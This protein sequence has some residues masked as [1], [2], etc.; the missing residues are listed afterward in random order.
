MQTRHTFE[1]SCRLIHGMRLPI[2]FT[3]QTEYGILLRRIDHR[4]PHK[5][6]SGRDGR[7]APATPPT[8]PAGCLPTSPRPR[9]SVLAPPN[10]PRPLPTSS[11]RLWTAVSHHSSLC[12]RSTPTSPPPHKPGI[13]RLRTRP[14]PQATTPPRPPPSQTSPHS[15]TPPPHK[16]PP[17]T[18][19]TLLTSPAPSQIHT[20]VIPEPDST[21]HHPRTNSTPGLTAIPHGD[22]LPKIRGF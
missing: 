2:S 5:A 20:P 11:R 13:A 15:T 17:N 3:T 19:F 12:E 7:I 6:E 9:A 10:T 1:W 22:I 18:P 14:S 8:P 16:H 21:H 4:E